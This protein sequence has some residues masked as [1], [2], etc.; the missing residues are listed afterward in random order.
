[1]SKDMEKSDPQTVLNGQPNGTAAVQN[2]Q[3]PNNKKID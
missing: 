2:T 1:M 3:M